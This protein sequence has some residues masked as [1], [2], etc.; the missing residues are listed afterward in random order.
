MAQVSRATWS[1]SLTT[2]INDNTSGDITPADVRSVLTDLEDSVTWYD[3]VTGLATSAITSGTFADARIAESNVT[4][5][6]AALTI[7]ESQISDF[8][9]SDYLTSTIL[10]STATGEG[11]ALIGVEDAGGNFTATDVEGVLAELA[12]ASGGFTQEQIEDFAGAM[13]SGNT[14]TGITATYQ[15]ADGTIDLVV[16]DTTVAG[17]TGS[18]GITPGDTLT[19]AGGTNVT[20][21][22]VGDT[23]TINA[24]GAAGDAWND[25]VDADIVPDGDG[26]RDLG[27][28]ATRFAES[29]VDTGYFTNGLVITEAADHP[30]TPAA[31]L[32]QLWVDNAV[33]Q[34]LQVTFDDGTDAEVLTGASGTSLT[35]AATASGDLFPF[36][37]VSDSDNPKTVTR[38][39]FISQSGIQ[40][41]PSEGAFV[42]GDKTKLDGI[43]ANA[44]VT[45]TANVTAAGAVMDSEVT[46]LA[47]VK[48]FDPADYATSAQGTTADSAMQDLVD[49]TTPQLG[50]A[51][52]GQGNEIAGYIN[53]VISATGALTAATHGGGI[54]LT[55][56]NITIPTTAGFTCVLVAGGAHTV[57][58][59]STTSAAMAAGDLMT[60]VVEDS[61]TIH[62]V[63]TAA[64]DKVSFT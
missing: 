57:T 4:Q 23:L 53:D 40:V 56:G 49:D 50:G 3:E 5:H 64:A 9:S 41:E 55:T 10:A 30:V 7:T 21:A 22:M 16:A 60:I 13:F 11:A 2:L 45:D 33:T 44:D 48:A 24:S 51:L 32:A 25:A 46:N 26:T 20:T 14:E 35:E 39:N 29:Y 8:A 1:T 28:T 15:D 27:A 63:L 61:T 38:A 59:N 31:G 18:T 52:D 42:D 36:F 58:F 12:G 62:A 37:D 47:D 43:E 54:I 34:T 17:D 6:E 19:I